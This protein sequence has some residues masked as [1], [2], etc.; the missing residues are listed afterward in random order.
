MLVENDYRMS[1]NWGRTEPGNTP[2]TVR[3]AFLL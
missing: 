1:D 2:D 3:Y